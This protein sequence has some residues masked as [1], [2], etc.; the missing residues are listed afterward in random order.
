[1]PCGSVRCCTEPRGLITGYVWALYGVLRYTYGTLTVQLGS[2]TRANTSPYATKAGST[3]KG[4]GVS[5]RATEKH[6]KN[7][8]EF[9]A[10]VKSL[11]EKV[12]VPLSNGPFSP[13]VG[14]QV[15]LWP[16]AHSATCFSLIR[17]MPARL[18]VVPLVFV[19][20]PEP[21]SPD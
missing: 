18:S 1:M 4:V 11:N 19:Y 13:L 12:G 14:P 16:P 5:I 15:P 20:W 9:G 8:I 3:G 10:S 7:A 21:H 17:R 2:R 6:C